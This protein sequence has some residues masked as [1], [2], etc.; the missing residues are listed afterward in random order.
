MTVFRER[1]TV[2]MERY[3]HVVVPEGSFTLG[4]VVDAVM[5]IHDEETARAFY[6]G[7]VAYEAH[8]PSRH[9]PEELVRSNIGWCFGE[10][11]EPQ[12]KAMWIRVCGAS[13]PVFGQ[14]DVTFKEAFA[15]GIRMGKEAP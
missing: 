7:Y 10:G 14:A 8:I 2:A 1:I 3:R 12:D 4:A 9:T 5:G 11:M 13:H 6:E 15:R